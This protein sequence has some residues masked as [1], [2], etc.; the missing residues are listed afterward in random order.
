MNQ[1]SSSTRTLRAPS[2]NMVLLTPRSAHPP[3]TAQQARSLVVLSL[4]HPSLSPVAQAPDALMAPALAARALDAP[5]GVAEALASPPVA[6]APVQ[7]APL[8]FPSEAGKTWG[9]LLVEWW[10][11]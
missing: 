1:T 4:A 9:L 10:L 7:D 2:N 8:A 3:P 5:S 11:L 6:A